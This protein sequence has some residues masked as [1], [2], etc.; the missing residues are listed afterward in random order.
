[1]W[2]G[3]AFGPIPYN[4]SCVDISCT[5]PQMQSTFDVVYHRPTDNLLMLYGCIEMTEMVQ[6][7]LEDSMPLILAMV[8]NFLNIDLPEFIMQIVVDSAMRALLSNMKIAHL[9]WHEVLSPNRPLTS[10]QLS[11]VKSF[12]DTFPATN[13][14][15]SG[16]WLDIL[17]P[18]VWM[19]R[20]MNYE[21]V[22]LQQVIQDP[23]ICF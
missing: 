8:K 1:M 2:N 5:D 6:T 7:L 14:G 21:Y 9:S 11:T 10:E 4:Y 22:Q 15:E 12:A 18:V 19:L 3:T 13:V 23:S 20:G 16:T 17:Y